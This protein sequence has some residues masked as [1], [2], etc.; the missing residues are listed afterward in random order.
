MLNRDIEIIKVMVDRTERIISLT[1]NVNN[2]DYIN[3]IDLQELVCFN[4]LQIG[5]LSNSLSDDFKRKHNKIPWKQIYGMRNIIVHGYGSVEHDIVFNTSKN[6][7]PD[8][9]KKLN[10]IIKKDD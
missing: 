8:L 6:S 10:A 1:K 7:I 2:K 4:I 5:E 3:N 9:N